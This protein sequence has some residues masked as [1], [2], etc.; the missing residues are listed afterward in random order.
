MNNIHNYVTDMVKTYGIRDL[1]INYRVTCKDK[2]VNN[3][4]KVIYLFECCL[5]FVVVADH[6]ELLLRLFVLGVHIL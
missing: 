6:K 2:S 4:K 1:N 5:M 3:E